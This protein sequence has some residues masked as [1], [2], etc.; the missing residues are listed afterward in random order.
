[1]LSTNKISA[2]KL[3]APIL[4]NKLLFYTQQDNNTI[5]QTPKESNSVEPKIA[6]IPTLK[7]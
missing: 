3:K 6:K 1:M 7:A 5:L 4:Q 2:P